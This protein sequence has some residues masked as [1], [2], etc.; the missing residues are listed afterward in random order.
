MIGLLTMK[1]A[2]PARLFA[3]VAGDTNRRGSSKYR[4]EPDTDAKSSTQHTARPEICLLRMPAKRVSPP[5]PELARELLSLLH[6]EVSRV[7]SRDVSCRYSQSERRGILLQG[8]G[9]D[10]LFSD[11][12]GCENMK[13]EF[14]CTTAT[15]TVAF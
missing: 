12:P 2:A 5:E 4:S 7:C 15:L 1:A 9:E 14:F 8:I 11:A 13:R 6:D 3:Y 10:S